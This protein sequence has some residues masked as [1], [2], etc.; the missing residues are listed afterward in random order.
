MVQSLI[1]VLHQIL[2][3]ANKRRMEELRRQQIIA[4]KIGHADAKLPKKVV[5]EARD[6]GAFF[7]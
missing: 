2:T 1:H 6:V 3:K 4:K 7:L 5:L